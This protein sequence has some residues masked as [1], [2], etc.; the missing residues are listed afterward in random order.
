[1]TAILLRHLQMAES[2]VTFLVNIDR[3]VVA[4]W[5]SNV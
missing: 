2:T 5:N 3:R 1:M 4:V